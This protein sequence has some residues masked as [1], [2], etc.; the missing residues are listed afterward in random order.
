MTFNNSGRPLPPI[1]ALTKSWG[2]ELTRDTS[3]RVS[4]ISFRSEF[5]ASQCLCGPS[6]NMQLQTAGDQQAMITHANT[7]TVQRIAV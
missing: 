7:H 2:A 3:G 4:P 5:R 6:G 1:G